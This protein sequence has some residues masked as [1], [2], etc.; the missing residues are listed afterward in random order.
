MFGGGV[1]SAL[2]HLRVAAVRF[3]RQRSGIAAVEFA[4][5]APLLQC[6]YF[7]T[8]ET[9]QGIVANKKVA[10]IGSMVAD[11]ITQQGTIGKAELDAI[12]QIGGSII[13]PYNRTLPKIVVTAIEITPDPGSKV[14]VA[15]SRKLVNGV[16]SVDAAKGATTTLPAALNVKG[17]F[18]IRVDSYLEYKP[19]ITWTA[20]QKQSL[21]LFS[22][23][24][25]I[26][27]QETYYLR[28]RMSSSITCSDC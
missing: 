18:L 23:F 3:V 19:L 20:T 7:L 24:D 10:R 6:M 12:M 9:S 5:I 4:L 14:Q 2:V 1:R 15:W 25:T 11:L 8:L 27:M 21:G 16:A 17:S 13:Q 26:S 28:P 22:A